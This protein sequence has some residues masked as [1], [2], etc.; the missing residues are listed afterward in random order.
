MKIAVFGWYGHN[1]AGDERIKYCLNSFLYALGGIDSVDFF[2]LHDNAAKGKTNKFDDYDLIIVGGGGLIYSQHNYHDFI[3]GLK[4]K[5]ITIGI[6]VEG[7]LIGNRGKFA[8]ALV[9]RSKIIIVRDYASYEKLA[10]FDINKTIIVS[11]DLTFLAPYDVINAL[12]NDKI[13]IN[14]FPKLSSP[15]DSMLNRFK[16][17][18]NRFGF[19]VELKTICFENLLRNLM[20]RFELLPI[21]LYCV[22][23]DVA[24][25]I[26]Q[27]NDV[28]FLSLYFENVPE[29]FDH[30]N[31]DQ[32]RMFVSMRL[33]GAIFA[34]Q[35]GIPV[36]TFATYPKQINFMKEIGLENLVV[37]L[38]D[39]QS[40]PNMIDFINKNISNISTQMQE[41]REKAV[42]QIRRDLTA[43]MNCVT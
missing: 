23:Q 10:S 26:Y 42:L 38:F 20:H 1:N 27:M 19:N 37:N 31:I 21:P 5:I 9:E 25:Y 41:Y 4:N 32:C 24:T 39:H 35:K 40:I 3:L 33:H 22:K 7:D 12:E 43:A 34:V 6:S 8:R 14:L 15:S 16:F 17:N 2:D 28:K 30:E 11:A 36:I 18:L 13:G 29:Y